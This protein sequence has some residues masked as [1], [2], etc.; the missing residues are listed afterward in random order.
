MSQNYGYQFFLHNNRYNI[1]RGQPEGCYIDGDGVTIIASATQYCRNHQQK[2]I[3][4]KTHPSYR[5]QYTSDSVIRPKIE[6]QSSQNSP[7]VVNLFT[8]KDPIKSQYIKNRNKAGTIVTFYTD[9]AKS[10]SSEP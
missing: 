2:E 6:R 7:A 10:H 8:I 4:Q 9:V 5:A 3:L 1:L